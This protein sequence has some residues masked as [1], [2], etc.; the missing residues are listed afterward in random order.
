MT[1]RLAE[2][3]ARAAELDKCVNCGL[4]QSVCPTYLQGGH[5]GLTARGKIL[6]M[7][8]MLAGEVAPSGS[9]A[10]LFDDCLTCYACQTVCPAGVRTEK[11]WTAARQDLTPLS[12]TGRKKRRGLYWTIG[13]PALFRLETRLAAMLW[14]RGG[15]QLITSE[16]SERRLISKQAPYLRLLANEYPATT[17]EIGSVGLLVGCSSN[18]VTTWVAD[19]VIKL[20]TKAGYRV[21]VPKEQV[22][23]G[24]PAINNGD[25]RMARYLAARNITL[26]TEVG[27]D[28]VTSP[29]GTCASAMRQDY[30][31]LFC[32]DDKQRSA[33]EELAN[34]VADI[35]SLAARAPDLGVLN[36]KRTG[37]SVTVHDSCHI[38][39]IGGNRWRDLLKQVPGLEVREM[40][41]ST[42]CCGFGGSY[43]VFHP[44]SSQAIARRKIER[45]LRTGA[46]Q[47]LVGS[48]GCLIHI[49]RSLK[50]DEQRHLKVKHFAEFLAELIP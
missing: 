44:E 46:S 39:H 8:G 4:C 18:L 9:I 17:S 3:A 19:A 48:P 23:C 32:E 1:Q 2:I 7:K 14:G 25:W 42:H 6:L 16:T 12:P 29:D 43:S 37:T 13:K 40:A 5:E 22:C 27:V 50:P 28:F 10:D 47:M 35:S 41:E 21:V 15:N 24:A 11:L 26:F 38:T 36:L 49:Q 31:E 30:L 34:K 20:L 33:A 45:A